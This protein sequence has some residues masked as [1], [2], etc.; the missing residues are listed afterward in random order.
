[1]TKSRNPY[2]NATGKG[3]GLSPTHSPYSAFKLIRIS[4]IPA[5]RQIIRVREIFSTRP[6][7][8]I[9]VVMINTLGPTRANSVLM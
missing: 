6:N 9:P 4:V 1:M 7:N 8:A 3:G 2:A 5:K